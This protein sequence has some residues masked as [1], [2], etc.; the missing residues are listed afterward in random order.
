MRKTAGF[1][2]LK[3]ESLSREHGPLAV[4]CVGEISVIHFL[5]SDQICRQ[6]L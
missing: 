2:V 1:D 4:S 6:F 5:V 3:E